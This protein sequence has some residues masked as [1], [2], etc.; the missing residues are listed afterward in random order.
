MATAQRAQLLKITHAVDDKVKDVSDTV[1]SVLDGMWGVVFAY[2]FHHE[3]ICDQTGK[4][5]ERLCNGHRFSRL[6]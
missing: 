1:R 6:Q 3:S 5:R 4:K 2:R